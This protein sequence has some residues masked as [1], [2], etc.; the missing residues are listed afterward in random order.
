MYTFMS[1]T[2]ELYSHKI[3]FCLDEPMQKHTSFRIG[4]PAD[5]FI[6]PAD[7]AELISTIALMRQAGIPYFIAGNLSNVVFDDAGYRGAVISTEKLNGI[8][9]IDGKLH[10][11]SG[12]SLSAAA[13][14]AYKHTLTGLEF[15][16]G[17][18]GTI[19]G[20]IYMNAG[21]YG[22]E[23]ANVVE[24]VHC[25]DCIN[26]KVKELN[27]TDCQF[28]YRYSVFQQSEMVL[29]STVLSLQNGDAQAIKEK[30]DT[31]MAARKSKQPLSFPNAGSVFKRPKGHFA[32]AM[33]EE[34]GLKGTLVG[35]AAV[36][37]KHAGFIINTG[38]ATCSDVK[39]LVAIIQKK[40]L[41]AY[42]IQLECEI[43]FVSS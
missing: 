39:E 13:S 9:H 42:G 24:Q 43:Q 31:Y 3:Q 27:R 1:L 18:P 11:G 29:L 10:C 22:G 7:E 16:Y 30:M 38:N 33:I 19:G 36:S 26:G 32:G 14:T 4:G 8:K 25:F 37:Q 17:I 34:L 23:M 5:Y 40:V 41:S 2:E 28:D 12:A 20:G 6:L 35:G 15:A 21:A